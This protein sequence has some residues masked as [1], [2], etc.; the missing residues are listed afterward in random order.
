M[1]DEVVSKWQRL[2][3]VEGSVAC[4]TCGAGARSDLPMERHICV[5]FGAAGYSKD[6][7]ALWDEGMA[8]IDDPD[9]AP[10]VGDVEKLA[11]ADPEH[12]WRIYF[13]APLYS[14]EYQRQAEGVW[15]LI[16]KGEGFA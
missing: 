2:P 13:E 11:V 14:A 4:L 16:R 8:S 10:T 3:A 12:D 7:E 6:G 5:G 1:S 9:E 15:V